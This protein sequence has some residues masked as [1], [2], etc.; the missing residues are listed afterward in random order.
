MKLIITGVRESIYQKLVEQSLDIIVALKVN[1]LYGLTIRVPAGV[2]MVTT[3]S[4]VIT[5]I[6]R[7]ELPTY[8]MQLN[9]GDFED[10]I[11]TH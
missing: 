9:Y 8:I 11:L 5:S 2:T 4:Y 1:G 10:I 3:D 6:E 7:Y